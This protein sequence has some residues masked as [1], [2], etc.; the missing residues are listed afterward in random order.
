MQEQARGVGPSA[1]GRTLG[2]APFG[3]RPCFTLCSLIRALLAGVF[4]VAPPPPP[5]P[6]A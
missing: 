5:N 4:F 1:A 3:R 6:H 2:A